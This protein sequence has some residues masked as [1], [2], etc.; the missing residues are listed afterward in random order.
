M[1]K[2]KKH[3]LITH[4]YVRDYKL[5]SRAHNNARTATHTIH[6]SRGFNNFQLRLPSSAD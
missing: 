4:N 3:I 6:T 5:L 2:R 1:K